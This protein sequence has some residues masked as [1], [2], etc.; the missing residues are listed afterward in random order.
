MDIYLS[1]C[2]V[3]VIFNKKLFTSSTGIS[4]LT[5]GNSLTCGRFALV[6]VSI[7]ARTSTVLPRPISSANIP[8]GGV[9][10]AKGLF[11]TNLENTEN[12]KCSSV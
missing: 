1:S 12:L 3:C 6:F 9:A 5:T 4:S 2:V 8:P 7:H 10:V 11:R